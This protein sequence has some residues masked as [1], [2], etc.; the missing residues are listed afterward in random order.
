MS[1]TPAEIQ[2]LHDQQDA[3]WAT[4]VFYRDL[5]PLVL[6]RSRTMRQQCQATDEQY[7]AWHAALV[8]QASRERKCCP[9]LTT[10]MT[11]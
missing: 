10:T 8:R 1:L 5:V 7:A 2:R 6:S 3:L 11:A 4:F 9:C